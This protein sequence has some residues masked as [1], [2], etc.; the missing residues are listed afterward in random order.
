MALFLFTDKS[1]RASLTLDKAAEAH[2]RKRV[3][4]KAGARIRHIFT[5]LHRRIL[6]RTAFNTGR[7]LGSWFAS[8]GRPITYDI[9]DRFGTDYFRW[10]PTTPQTNNL[11]VG[12]ESG[13]EF[14][15]K[16]SLR[17]TESINFERN[18]FQ[19]FFLSNGAKLDSGNIET[20]DGQ[21]LDGLPSD[22]PQGPGSRAAMQEFGVIAHFDLF[23][24]YGD[25]KIYSFTPR[26][27]N[28]VHM[29]VN[30]IRR[31]YL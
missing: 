17:T 19:I 1:M 8:T 4:E 14:F 2:F 21:E 30:E 27:T 3:A 31:Q 15:E 5:D 13:R 9:A 26:G 18:P 7:T 25:T 11:E 20:G 6:S 29:A 22:L 24:S 10:R 23:G 12:A 16:I 28:A